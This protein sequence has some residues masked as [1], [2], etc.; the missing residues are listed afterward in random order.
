M[1][2]PRRRFLCSLACAAPWW[3]A[4]GC[5]LPRRQARKSQADLHF[6]TRGV[7]ISAP[8]DIPNWDWPARAHAAGLSTIATHKFPGEVARFTSTEVWQRFAEDC[9]RLG[10]EIE[11]E[12]HAIYDLLPRSLFPKHPEMFRMNENGE[13]TRDYNLCVSS[14]EAVAIVCENAVRYSERLRPTTGRYFYWLDDAKG[15]CRC[16]RCKA[17]SDSDQALLLEN[18]MLAALRRADPRATLAHLAYG[19]T[20]QPPREVRP[21]PG[22]FLEW[23]PIHRRFDLPIGRQSEQ[24]E[25]LDANLA[26]FG[27]EGA[28]VLD[29]VLD[30]SLHCGYRRNQP[31]PLPWNGEMFRADLATYRQRGIR[32]YTSFAVWINADYVRACGEPPL[33]EYGAGLRL[34]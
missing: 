4:G 1:L 32:H 8:D 7:V 20:W 21:E 18:A 11:H 16:D 17:L 30:E 5:G 28:Q 13:R 19:T 6:Q 34:P 3:Y 2:Q 9:G 12:L 31:K 22:V 33:A 24:I 26:V 14:A 23:A 25:N 15:M 29:Y 10:L 27:H